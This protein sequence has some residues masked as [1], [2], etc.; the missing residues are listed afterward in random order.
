[1][2]SGG[3]TYGAGS[4]SFNTLGSLR[5]VCEH[6]NNLRKS[7]ILLSF[8]LSNKHCDRTSSAFA[9]TIPSLKPTIYSLSTMIV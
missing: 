6:L 8:Q 9:I 7:D 2:H 4:L 3:E 1:M 5:K